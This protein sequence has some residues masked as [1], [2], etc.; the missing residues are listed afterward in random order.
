MKYETRIAKAFAANRIRS[1]L[2]VDDA[3]DPPELDEGAV[4]ALLEFL[5]TETNRE[6]IVEGGVGEDVVDAARRAADGGDDALGEVY[7]SL[8]SAFIDGQKTLDP[9]GHFALRRGPA[10]ND[11]QPLCALLNKCGDCGEGVRVETV[12]LEDGFARYEEDPPE[13]LFLDY[14]LD[15]DVPAVGDVGR[16]ALS[17]ARRQ[18]LDFLKDVVR[19][20]KEHDYPAVVLMSSRR[21]DDRDAFRKQAG[22]KL[23]PL[24]FRALDKK[25]LQMDGGSVAVDHA[26]ADALLDTFQGYRFGKLF[27]GSLS[28]WKNGVRKALGEFEREVRQWDRRD[29][30][31]LSRFRLREEGQPLSEYLEW[32]FGGY[33]GALME[34]H[35]DWGHEAIRE[36]GDE[37][38][39][40]DIEGAYEGATDGIARCFHE[41]RVRTQRVGPGYRYRLGDL[42]KESGYKS[43]WAIVTPDCDLVVRGDET[44]AGRILALGGVLKEFDEEGAAADNFVVVE[45]MPYSLSWKPKDLKTFPLDGDGS[46]RSDEYEFIGTLRGLYAQAI[47]R[48]ALADLGRVGVPVAPSLGIG[49]GVSA[50]VRQ[51]G[52]RLDELTTGGNTKGVLIPAREGRSDGSRVLLARPFVWELVEALRS[53]E[54]GKLGEDEAESLRR[55]LAAEGDFCDWVL[56]EGGVTK[57]VDKLKFGVGFSIG[58]PTRKGK[59]NAW[60]WLVVSVPDQ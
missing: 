41:V 38:V 12:G 23:V 16:E 34:R 15:N 28:T 19:V 4:A 54:D 14:Y 53:Y 11:L 21:I 17:T 43:V 25:E 35:V 39:G 49:V 18:S 26:A 30:A 9:G 5:E 10:L 29:I 6:T 20:T 32:L 13:V 42:Y 47:Q 60:L 59:K 24:R 3:Y 36:L 56:K 51:K 1:V 37:E 50:F 45:D 33:F 27:Q 46:L 40:D 55:L 44:R 57:D 52:G 8:Y 48:R 31:Y 22:K 2:V 7:R 58:R